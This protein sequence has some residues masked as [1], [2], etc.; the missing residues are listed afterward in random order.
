MFEE[1][2]SPTNEKDKMISYVA[3]SEEDK[4]ISS[5]DMSDK[6]KFSSED[7]PRT[8]TFVVKT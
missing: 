5:N 1:K 4:M 7:T 8:K 3:T 2:T 6:K